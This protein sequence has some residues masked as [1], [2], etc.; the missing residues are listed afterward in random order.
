MVQEASGSQ[1]LL[2]SGS[3]KGLE[4]IQ[5]EDTRPSE[6]T[7]KEQS[8]IAPTEETFSPVVNIRAIRILLAIAMFYDYEIWKMDVKIAFLNSHLSEE[9]ASRNWNKRF[10]EEIEKIGFTQNP[11][12]P[13]V[14]LKASESDVVFLVL[15]V[16]DILLMGNSV[17]MLQEKF[18]M[19]N[20]KKGYT[21]MVEKPDYRKLQGAKTPN[22]VQRMGIVPCALAIVWIRKFTDGLGGVMPSNK[23][24]MEMLF[25]NEPVIAITGDLGILKEARYFQRKYHY[26]REVIRRGEIILKKVYT[27]DNAADPFTKPVPLIFVLFPL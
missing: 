17:A 7:S 11:D 5:R 10:N 24:P 21:L 2:E 25:D 15:Y 27:D 23:T 14:Y 26:I 3:D 22:E 20:S 1:G 4:I 16:D 19:E 8:E 18:R 13:C 9:Q 6:N 12:E